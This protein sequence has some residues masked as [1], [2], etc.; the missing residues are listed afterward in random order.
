MYYIYLSSIFLASY[1]C[2]AF[3]NYTGTSKFPFRAL[4]IFLYTVLLTLKIKCYIIW[5]YTFEDNGMES[6]INQ[7][8]NEDGLIRKNN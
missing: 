2:F 1:L 3:K 8:K 4:T 5:N 6:L 7:T